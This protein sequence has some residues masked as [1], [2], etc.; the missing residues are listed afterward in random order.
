MMEI[1]DCL[2]AESCSQSEIVGGLQHKHLLKGLFGWFVHQPE[3]RKQA[4]LCK[5]T[6]LVSAG[7]SPKSP[8]VENNYPL[9]VMP[10]LSSLAVRTAHAM[11]GVLWAMPKRPRASSK[12]KP[13][14]PLTRA[15]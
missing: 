14:C 2:R 8:R 10:E 9:R 13:P 7:G 6:G 4:G 12:I 1:P 3:G 11:R 15:F 5:S